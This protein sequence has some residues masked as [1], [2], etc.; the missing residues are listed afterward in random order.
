MILLETLYSVIEGNFDFLLVVDGNEKVIYRSP[1]LK[2]CCTPEEGDEEHSHLVD[3]LDEESL[4]SFRNAVKNVAKGSRG[5]IALFSSKLDQTSAIPMKVGYVE[6]VQGGIYLFFGAQVDALRR[7]SD[8][9]K[10]ERVKEL[11]CLYAVAEWIEV[12]ASI[13]EFF[14]RLPDYLSRGMRFPD[15]AVVYSIYQEEEYG[16][17]PASDEYISVDLVV[18]GAPKGEIRVGYISGSHELLPE[19]QKML[20]EIGRMLS[21]ALERKELRERMALKQEEEEELNRRLSKL[22]EEI[23]GREKEL[24][25]QNQ[26]LSTADS[27]LDRVNRSW[28]ETKHRLETMFR[29]IPGEVMLIDM[30][31]NVVMSNQDDIDPG[32][33]CYRTYFNRDIPCRDCRLEKIKRDKTPITITIADGE[34]F[35]EV[36]TLPVYNQEEEVDGILEFYRDVTLEK[37]YEQ[38]IQQ[39]DKLASLGQLVSG[40]GHEINNPNQ[41]IRGN[42]KIIRQAITDMLPIIDRYAEDHPDLKIARLKYDFFREHIMTLIDDMSHGS[43]RIKGIVEGLRGFARKDEGLLVDKVDVNTLLEAT[44]RLVKNEVHKHAEIRLDL[45]D[46]IEK[47]TGNSQKIEQ[48][49]VNLIVNSAQ[50]IPDDRKGLIEVRTSMDGSDVVIEVEDNGRGMDEKTQK[51]IFDPFFTTKRAK[52]GTGLGLAIAFRII[53]EHSGSIS[54]KS[55]SGKGTIFTI[56]IPAG[57][58]QVAEDRKVGS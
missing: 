2:R 53:E 18:S 15:E 50:A 29:A 33:K 45:G 21:L 6:S 37:T 42:I 34:R 52:G 19:E 3:I 44:T 26:K 7:I 49:F 56:R 20:N 48:V 31:R 40:I 46:D 8:W 9:E 27:Y 14:T 58:S 1:L 23:S 47:F 32:D 24:E 13:S 12:S 54:V 4:A 11:S 28:E 57:K 51:Q 41:F 35:L 55:R 5:V 38:Q 43:E 17:K 10:E 25:E 30:N 16:Q 22:E 39:A 36:H